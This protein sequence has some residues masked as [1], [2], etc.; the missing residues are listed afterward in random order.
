MRDLEPAEPKRCYER[1]RPGEMI[2]LDIKKLGRF[3][4]MGHRVTSDRT[5]QSNS[6]GVGWEYVHVCVDDHSRI[7]FTDILPDEKA[8]SAIVLLRAAVTY[9]ETPGSK[10]ERM[11]MDDGSYYKSHAF[12]AACKALGVRHIRGKP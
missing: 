10:V 9:Y 7:A 12:R 8:V 1:A 5:G 4:R 3:E 6:R 2:H 11:M